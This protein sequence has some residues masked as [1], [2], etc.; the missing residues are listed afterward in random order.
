MG[1]AT[2]VRLNVGYTLKVKVSKVSTMER[3]W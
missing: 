3:G 1:S 2:N